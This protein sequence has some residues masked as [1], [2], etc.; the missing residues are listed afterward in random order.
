MCGI[1][2]ENLRPIQIFPGRLN[3]PYLRM[4]GVVF[5]VSAPDAAEHVCVLPQVADNR[6]PQRERRRAV[7]VKR[8]QTLEKKQESVF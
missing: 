5:H 3:D 2:D 1:N 4:A 7:C 8:H 6:R